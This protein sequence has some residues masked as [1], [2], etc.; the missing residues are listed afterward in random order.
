MSD[1]V[2]NEPTGDEEKGPQQEESS[3]KEL[4]PGAQLAARRE[5]LDLSI[6]QVASHLNLAPRQIQAIESD[7][8]SALPG[9]ATARGFVRSYAKLLK[10]DATPLLE[11][12]AKETTRDEEAAPLRRALPATRFADSRLSASSGN[13]WFSRAISLAVLMVFLFAGLFITQQIGMHSMLPEFLRVAAGNDAAG[14]ASSAT[15]EMEKRDG[16]ASDS[17]GNTEV[18]KDANDIESGSVEADLSKEPGDTPTGVVASGEATGTKSVPAENAAAAPP[19]SISGDA[20][21]M[22]TIKLRE[23]SWIEVKRADNSIVMSSLLKAGTSQSFKLTGPVAMTI[24]NASGVEVILR[25][26]PV[27]MKAD[28]KT[29]VARLNLK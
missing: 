13:R 9:M 3:S 23:D 24:G 6:V 2:G 28:A 17:D 10:V 29:N 27:E 15:A 26:K 1:K 5:E 16:A 22:L 25:G 4:S 12:I 8:Y 18:Q 20:K 21:D 14:Q 19:R 7:N 11:R